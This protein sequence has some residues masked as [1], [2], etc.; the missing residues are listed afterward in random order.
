[1]IAKTSSQT[2][3]GFVGFSPSLSTVIVAHQGTDATQLYVVDF[4]PDFLVA[5]LLIGTT[6]GTAS[7]T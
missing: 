6:L 1:M 4:S 3:T 2:P 7:P 5:I